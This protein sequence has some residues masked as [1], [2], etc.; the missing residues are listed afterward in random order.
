[1]DGLHV[2]TVLSVRIVDGSILW[3]GKYP[4]QP[5]VDVEQHGNDDGGNDGQHQKFSGLFILEKREEKGCKI[6]QYDDCN[7]AECEKAF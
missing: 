2:L 6:E 1:M 5:Q 4:E 3:S 7:T